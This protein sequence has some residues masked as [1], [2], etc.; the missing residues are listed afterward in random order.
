MFAIEHRGAITAALATAQC[1]LQPFFDTAFAYRFDRLAGDAQ[2][3]G[4]LPI[5]QRRPVLSLIGLQQDV[6]MAP[7]VGRRPS[8]PDQF[9]QFG[10]FLFA[11][12]DHVELFHNHPSQLGSQL[13]GRQLNMPV[14][15]VE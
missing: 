5:M 4:D 15:Y 8:G 14:Y 13:T 11:Q 2:L 9:R 12:T 7:A 1:R 10:P 3:A 6:C